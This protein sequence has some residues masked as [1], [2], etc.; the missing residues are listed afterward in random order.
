MTIEYKS[1]MI[2]P[3]NYAEPVKPVP[4]APPTQAQVETFMQTFLT[5][6]PLDAQVVVEKVVIQF[7]IPHPDAKALVE[8]VE[9]K[10]HPEKYAE[11][12]V[13]PEPKVI[14]G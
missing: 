10:W 7:G 12:V 1:Y 4:P 8:A 9:K 11:P 2:Y 3:K 14:E 6:K 13:E 5:A